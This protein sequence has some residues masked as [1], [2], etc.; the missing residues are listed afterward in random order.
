M[1]DPIETHLYVI[2]CLDPSVTARYIGYT[3]NWQTTLLYHSDAYDFGRNFKLKLY[4]FVRNH[5]GWSNWEFTDLGV[6]GS[7][8]E[9]QFAKDKMLLR[10][11]FQLNTRDV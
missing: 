9:A 10:H 7:R 6:Y 5:G 2:S 8:G 1:D 4:T 3:T 11:K